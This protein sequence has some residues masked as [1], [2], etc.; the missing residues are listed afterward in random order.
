MAAETSST[1]DA[2]HQSLTMAVAAL[3]YEAGYESVE[4]SVMETLME[5]LQSYLTEI[6]RSTHAYCELGGR[7][8][9][10]NLDVMSAIADL[11]FTPNNLIAYMHRTERINLGQLTKTNE[12][13]PAPVLQVGKS[14][15]FPNYVPST[16]NYPHYP[17]PHAYI[18]TMTGQTPENDYVILRER[19]S[20]QKRDVERALT[21]FVAKTGR[22]LPLLPDD[23]NAFPLIAAEPST[24]P[25]LSAI[26]PSDLEMQKLMEASEEKNNERSEK[27]VGDAQSKQKQNKRQ[28]PPNEHS[29]SNSVEGQTSDSNRVIV[30]NAGNPHSS[31]MH[32][33]FL[34]PVKNP[35]SK[36][37]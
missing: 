3:C 29:G 5:M 13:L 11:G 17:D 18:R 22:S 35:K 1:A 16:F 7:T 32:N 25:Y 30:S 37:K 4:E 19:T 28:R 31:V 6:G 8:L 33:P 34:R 26:L 21:R 2:N 23:K 10:T 27:D 9:P 20:S 15:N 14:I 12:T 36:R 24:H